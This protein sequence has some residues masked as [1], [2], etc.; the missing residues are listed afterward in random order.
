M[1]ETKQTHVLI[2]DDDAGFR[3]ALA[4]DF[5]RKGSN[6]LQASNG[7][8]ALRI[9]LTQPVDVILSDVR[10][11][12]GDGKF[13]LEEVRKVTGKTPVF[14]FI[15]GFAELDLQDVYQLGVEAVFPK[16]F[17]RKALMTTVELALRAR[18]DKNPK[19]PIRRE[20]HKVNSSLM[21]TIGGEEQI[22]QLPVQ[23]IG[24]GGMFVVTDGPFPEKGTKL[25]FAI[26]LEGN[27]AL[28][29]AAVPSDPQ[30]NGVV[31]WIRD[32]STGEWPMGIGIEFEGLNPESRIR[33]TELI[34]YLKTG[35][36]SPLVAKKA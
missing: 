30:G 21:L 10:M 16:P 32:G 31:R 3:E 5:R 25:K 36:P 33:L 8:E 15:S 19:R 26:T 28:A 18:E 1:G 11:P 12:D 17:D 35:A 2:V 9:F 27:S 22:L 23:N 24:T 34:N 4:F 20:V 13:L 6:I 14:I 7:K 29:A